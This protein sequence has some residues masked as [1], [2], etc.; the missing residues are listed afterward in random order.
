ML[1]LAVIT[2]NE[3]DRLRAALESVPFAA[4]RLVLDSGS[5]DGTVALARALGCR[6]VET[7]WPG[8]IA[9]KNR[10]LALATQPWVLSLD[11]DERLD[12]VAARS[13]EAALWAPESA[14]GF[15]LERHNRWL[16]RE[17]SRG[18][19]G[20]E[21]KVRVVRA[22]SGVWIGKNPHDHLVVSGPV[23]TL[24]GV[25]VHEP[26]RDLAEHLATARRYAQM[27]RDEREYSGGTPLRGAL[28]AGGHLA[29][30][31]LWRSGWRDGWPGFAVAG[32]GAWH[33]WL[34]WS[35]TPL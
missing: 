30:A 34:K 31:L 2:L 16:G 6:V 32:I 24:A 33:S 25:I 23:R 17:L 27:A 20:S 15:A 8:H 28:H 9:Q 21:R 4:E 5:T 12:E 11:A 29:D 22:G 26:Y 10:A 35:G 1:T 19:W 18:R 14:L 7:D 3:A 13:L